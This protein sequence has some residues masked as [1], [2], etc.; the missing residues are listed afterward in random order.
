MVMQ[1]IPTCTGFLGNLLLRL[2]LKSN[3]KPR[4][5]LG[6]QI[7]Y[8]FVKIVMKYKMFLGSKT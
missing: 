8:L 3:I 2:L 6:L 4:S 7:P 5:N 1:A